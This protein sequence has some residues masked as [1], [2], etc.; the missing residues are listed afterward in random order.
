MYEWAL[1]YG[2][3]KAA[4]YLRSVNDIQIKPGL[5]S[6]R[7]WPIVTIEGVHTKIRVQFHV[8]VPDLHC[9]VCDG[10]HFADPSRKAQYC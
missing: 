4:E 5:L 3:D 8:N 7:S 6:A 10:L 9:P 2:N 1:I